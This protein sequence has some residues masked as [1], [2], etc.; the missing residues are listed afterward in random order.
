MDRRK[1]CILA[2]LG[3]AVEIVLLNEFPSTKHLSL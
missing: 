1:G 3:I 2:R